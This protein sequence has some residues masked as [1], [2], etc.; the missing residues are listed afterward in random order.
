MQF[1]KV[2]FLL[3]QILPS[4]NIICCVHLLF[5]TVFLDPSHDIIQRLVSIFR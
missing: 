5:N 3:D 4:Q 2:C 1:R